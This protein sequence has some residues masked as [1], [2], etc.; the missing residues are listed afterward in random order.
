MKDTNVIGLAGCGA[1]GLPMAQQLQKAGYSVLGFDV[2][3]ADRFK[4]FASRMI[5]DPS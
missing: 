5:E 2:R 1:M 4:D 3:P